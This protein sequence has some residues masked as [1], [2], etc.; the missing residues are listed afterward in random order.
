MTSY[1]SDVYF[2][3]GP[4]PGSY[5]L[6]TV[7]TFRQ[8]GM[9]SSI[10]DEFVKNSGLRK[11]HLF[12]IGDEADFLAYWTSKDGIQRNW[13]S[14]AFTKDYPNL[15]PIVIDW[16]KKN[17]YGSLSVSI[18][19]RVASAACPSAGDWY[20]WNFDDDIRKAL[21]SYKGVRHIATGMSQSTVFLHQGGIW[22]DLKGQY[23]T[24]H[25]LIKNTHFKQASFVALNPWR[26]DEFIIVDNNETAW[27]K[28]HYTFVKDVEKALRCEA[29]MLSRGF[30]P[31]KL[32]LLWLMWLSGQ[33]RMPPSK[34]R[35]WMPEAEARLHMLGSP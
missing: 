6:D 24:L 22:Y 5:L 17:G 19:H 16:A 32:R 27:F 23:P 10:L 30:P 2:T 28:L 26:Q 34:G 33:I 15:G 9:P 7:R 31:S 35:L 25:N 1:S 18:G 29:A 21:G 14:S 20:A 4:S 13:H 11:I 12:A 8:F 3:F